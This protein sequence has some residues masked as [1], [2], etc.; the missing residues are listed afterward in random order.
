MQSMLS[1]LVCLTRAGFWL[2]CTGLVAVVTVAH[3]RALTH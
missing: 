3:V 1:D 2:L